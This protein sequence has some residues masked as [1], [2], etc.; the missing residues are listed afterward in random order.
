MYVAL[1]RLS[2]VID[3]IVGSTKKFVAECPGRVC[4]CVSDWA[5]VCIRYSEDSALV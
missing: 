4:V 5:C 3:N 1:E 2:H